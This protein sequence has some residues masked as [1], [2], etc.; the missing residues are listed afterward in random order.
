MHDIA[1]PS[2]GA[3]VYLL[4]E[5]NWKVWKEAVKREEKKARADFVIDNTRD[6]SQLEQ[7][8]IEFLNNILEN[9]TDK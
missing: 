9:Y 2:N 7:Q 4:L 1:T 6:K 8:A 5:N 3:F